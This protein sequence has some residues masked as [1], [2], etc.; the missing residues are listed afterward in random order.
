MFFSREPVEAEPRFHVGLKLTVSRY[1]KTTFLFGA[2]Q[3]R[4]AHPNFGQRPQI[5]RQIQVHIKTRIDRAEIDSLARLSNEPPISSS[6]RQ[7]G[8]NDLNR[9]SPRRHRIRIDI[10]PDAPH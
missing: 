5:G 2:S 10:A 9:R 7:I 6:L 4:V 8:E 3:G 1:G